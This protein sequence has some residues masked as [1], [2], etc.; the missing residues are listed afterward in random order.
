MKTVRGSSE[1][2][3]M[4]SA[5]LMVFADGNEA[6]KNVYNKY[7]H[8]IYKRVCLNFLLQKKVDKSISGFF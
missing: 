5:F 4:V 1:C 3:L 6:I 8:K 7:V 2:D